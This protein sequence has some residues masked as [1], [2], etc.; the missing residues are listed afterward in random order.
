MR[1]AQV[2][3]HLLHRHHGGTLVGHWEAAYIAPVVPLARGWERQLDTA[4][5]P[6]FYGQAPL[7]PGSYRAWLLD[8]GV[9]YVALPDAALDFAAQGEAAVI[10]AGV[11]G[12]RPVWRGAHWRV[13]GLSGSPGIVSG[14]AHLTQWGASAIRLVA[15][16]PGNVVV[17]VRYSANWDVDAGPACVTR[18]PGGWIGL[19]TRAAGPVTLGVDAFAPARQTC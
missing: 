5:N 16:A 14:P 18:A 7:T 13:Y 19:R 4:D 2:A 3:R 1:I 15:R 6:L 8:N 12:L 9:R 10:R 11:P 17:R